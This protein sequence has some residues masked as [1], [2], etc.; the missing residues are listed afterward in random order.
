MIDVRE[1]MDLR[2]LQEIQDD[3][4]ATTGMAAIAVD[5]NSKYLTEPSNFT[6][7][8]MKYT[9]G[10]KIGAERCLKCD[11]EC[12]GT[13]F[14]HAGLMDFS[15]DIVVDGEKIGA[16]LGGQIL[17]GP[18]DLDKF[19]E[20]AKELGIDPEEYVA[21]VKKVTIS[22]EKHIRAAAKLLGHVMNLVVNL[23]YHKH[24]NARIMDTKDD[25]ARASE[26][27][28]TISAT[29]RDLRGIA[30]KQRILSLNASIEAARSGVAGAGFAVVAKSMQELVGQ[31]A[32]IY[33]TIDSKVSDMKRI[34]ETLAD[35]LG[36]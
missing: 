9:R 14:C 18:P 22:D 11:V 10:S 4:A 15:N 6:D 5:I 31:S 30:Q 25:I 26:I 24:T 28:K 17:P 3:W 36:A 29:S 34:I 27:V 35:A 16:I 21:A 23:E 8:C 2:L 19:R 12:K 13:Y 33:G 1:F 20:T 32:E 7:F